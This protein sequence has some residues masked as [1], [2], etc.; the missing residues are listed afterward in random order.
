MSNI[1][2]PALLTAFLILLSVCGG[3]QSFLD[4]T[5]KGPTTLTPEWTEI[6]VTPPLQPERDEHDIVL[7]L[8]EP[9]GRDL[10]AKGV[11]LPDGSV[12]TPDIQLIDSDGKT[13][14]LTYVGHR[15]PQ[16]VR[17]TLRGRLDNREY[18]K[19]RIRS[20]KPVKCK[21]IIWS[22]WNWKDIQ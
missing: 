6:V 19:V 2:E 21:E 15:G 17:F 14:D 3:R 13:Y 9:F 20:E 8:E 7:Y 1:I 4:R 11:R 12:I 5:I 22:N 10:Q 18:Q 16:L